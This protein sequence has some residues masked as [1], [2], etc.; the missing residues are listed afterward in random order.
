MS[1]DSCILL[2][3]SIYNNE[4]KGIHTK[5]KAIRDPGTLKRFFY[6]KLKPIQDPL[7]G[8]Q[9]AGRL[10]VCTEICLKKETTKGSERMNK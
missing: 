7:S 6:T 2:A 8:I 5:L 4:K 10:P 1:K 9:G 3:K